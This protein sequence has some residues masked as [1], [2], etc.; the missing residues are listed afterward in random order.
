[1]LHELFAVPFAEIAALVG[2]TPEACRQLASRARRRVD[3]D[4]AAR[5]RVKPA[6]HRQVV[7]RFAAA[8]RSGDLGALVAVLDPD[9]SGDFDSG[10]ALP[11]APLGPLHG[12]V[13]IAHLIKRVFDGIPCLLDVAGVNGEPGVVVSLGGRVVAVI[14]I[15][16]SHDRVKLIHAV[17]NPDKLPAPAIS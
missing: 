6:E 10:G 14:S 3:A 12:A 9:V 5:F 11:G 1:M 8:C 17:G 7:D 16:V 4:P 2:R 15:V 13:P